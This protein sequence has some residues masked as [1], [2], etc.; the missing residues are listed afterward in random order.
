MVYFCRNEHKNPACEKPARE[1]IDIKIADSGHAAALRRH[2]GVWPVS[3][4]SIPACVRIPGPIGRTTIGPVSAVQRGAR[5]W[6]R[7]S[8]AHDGVMRR[9]LP[10]VLLHRHTVGGGVVRQG[11]KHCQC[12]CYD[13]DDFAQR[14]DSFE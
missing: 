5:V 8:R 9:D 14:S 6:I 11:E 4:L 3:A 2:T 1:K 13:A 7:T 10:G 12:R